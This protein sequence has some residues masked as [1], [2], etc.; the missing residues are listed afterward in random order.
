M[1]KI[2]HLDRAIL[3]QLQRDASQ[4][5]GDIADKVG[6]S[7][8][9][10]WRRIK[11]LE[12]EG[13]IRKRVALLDSEKTGHGLTVFV[14][15]KTSEHSEQWLES[16]SAAV[17]RIEEVVEF[18]RMAGEIDY[19]LKIV[20]ADMADYDRIYKK[21]IQAGPFSDVSARFSMERIKETTELPL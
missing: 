17:K 20:A 2:D 10:C 7:T 11:R 21:L 4:S 16:F 8:N 5:V 15:L 3:K 14:S 18:H 1:E 9:P 13:L 6:L 12:Q 19:L